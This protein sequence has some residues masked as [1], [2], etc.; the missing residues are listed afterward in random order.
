MSN[1]SLPI[2]GSVGLCTNGSALSLYGRNLFDAEYFNALDI[3]RQT[4]YVGEPR[5]I[6]IELFLDW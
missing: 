3:N 2:Q 5:E 4:A 6:G 1:V